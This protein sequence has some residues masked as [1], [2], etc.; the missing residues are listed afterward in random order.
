ML[1]ADSSDVGYPPSIPYKNSAMAPCPF[2]VEEGIRFG[3]GF[4]FDLRARILRRAGRTL[5]LERIPLEILL[6]LIEQQGE[7]VNREQIVERIWGKSVFLDT[8]NSINGAIRKIR[9]SLR[10]DAEQPRYIQTITG[11]GYR[12]IAPVVDPAE[13]IIAEE[14]KVTEE[15]SPAPEH[16]KSP[17]SEE[18][19]PPAAIAIAQKVSHALVRRRWIQ[20]AAACSTLL[21]FIGLWWARSNAATRPYSAGKVMLAVLPFENLT[22]YGGDSYFSDGFTEEMIVQLGRLD[23]PHLGV[24]ARTSVMNYRS[25]HKALSEIARELGV[26]YVVEGSVRREA[27]K[28]RITAE[29]V[30]VGDQTHLWAREYDRELNDLLVVQSEIAQEVADEVELT[31]TH[32]ERHSANPHSTPM[33]STAYDAYDLYLKGRYF[34]NRRTREGFRQAI[35][36]FQQA[37]AKNPRDGRAYTGLADS[38]AMMSGYSLAPAND[39]MPKARDAALKALQLDDSL[40]EAHTSLAIISQNYNWD[41]QTAEKE[42][43]RAIQLNPNYA[44][45]HHWYAEFLALQDRFDESLEESERARQLDPLSLIIAADNAAIFYF[46]R[47]YDRAIERFRAVL[48][49]DPTFTRAHLIIPAYVQKKQFKQALADIATWRQSEKGP[50]TWAWEAYVY[51]RMGDTGKARHALREIQRT[52]RGSQMAPASLLA[53]AYLGMNEKDRALDWIEKAAQEHGTIPITLRVDPIYDPLRDQRRFQK[54]LEQV[55]LKR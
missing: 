34:W 51:G 31:L 12:F 2:G 43:R 7:V 37:I 26:Q 39:A 17:D 3:D 30:Q 47:Q 1:R 45:A 19:V 32:D 15:Y 44:T 28:V 13:A 27:N 8:D 33:S 9:Q 41:G 22:G 50:A 25:T 20:L 36:C 42:Y 21:A 29:L 40:A 24:I 16:S 54:L 46:S 35:S 5:K 14:S 52:S 23:P 11:R 55:S 6:Y 48:D 38:Y 49:M 10:D 18:S 4:E 53:L